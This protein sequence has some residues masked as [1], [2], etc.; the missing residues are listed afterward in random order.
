MQLL[1]TNTI[2][3]SSPQKNPSESLGGYPSTSTVPSGIQGAIFSELSNLDIEKDRKNYIAI[4][5]K[6]E[7]EVTAT[8]IS[9]WVEPQETSLCKYKVGIQ[10]LNSSN[11]L[12]II[13]ST[14]SK[15]YY[16]EFDSVDGQENAISIPNME[17][18]DMLGIWIERSVNQELESI[19]ERNNPQYLYDHKDDTSLE[20]EGFS[21]KINYT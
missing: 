6:N 18:G 19:K 21:L 12:E 3:Q 9:F 17:A 15:P 7:S 14:F 2:Q 16:V 10:G 13:E 4:I 20:V 1:Y 5:L 8:E 11:Q